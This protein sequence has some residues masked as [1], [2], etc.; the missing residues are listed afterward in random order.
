[1]GKRATTIYLLVTISAIPPILYFSL[2]WECCR[3]YKQTFENLYIFSYFL[4]N[5]IS[6][7]LFG[8]GGWGSNNLWNGG[9][10]AIV[11][12]IVSTLQGVIMLMIVDKIIVVVKKVVGPGK[13]NS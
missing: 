11:F 5:Y 6:K 12:L 4:A 2:S 8:I 7:A 13:N 9:K 1:M 10:F 3:T